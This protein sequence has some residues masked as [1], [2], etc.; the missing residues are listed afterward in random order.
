[1]VTPWF[2]NL[3]LLPRDR[4]RWQPLT[5]GDK[6][7]YAF[8]AGVYEFIGATDA[9]IGDYQMCSLFS[10]VQEFEDQATARLVA[11]LA[12]EAL[13]DAAERRAAP[14]SRRPTSPPRPSARTRRV[15]SAEM[16]ERVDGADVQARFPA[17]PRAW[18]RPRASRAAAG[19]DAAGQSTEAVR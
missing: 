2:M 5:I 3:A 10:P 13:F 16:Q 11:D 12:R 14:I 17:R 18:K 6:R 15:R 8:P 4:A 19:T 1:M 9:A 7:K